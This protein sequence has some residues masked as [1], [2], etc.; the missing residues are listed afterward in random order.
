MA[1]TIVQTQ[2]ISGQT[3]LGDVVRK[4]PSAIETLN[5]HGIQCSGCGVSY[6]ET[7][8]QSFTEKSIS[9]EDVQKIFVELNELAL[10]DKGNEGKVLVITDKAVT[11]LQGFLKEYGGTGLKIGL[12]PGGCAG[13]SY[14][15]TIAKGKEEGEEVV[16]ESGV[17]VFVTKDALEMMKGSKIDY[18]ESLQGAGFKIS[19]PNATSTCGCGQ[20]FR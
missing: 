17:K 6:T 19:N 10:Q 12:S 1:D 11:K 7:L 3:T 5:K 16:E 2:L 20:S 4:Y 13:F 18:V 15:L 14:D 8:E 9:K